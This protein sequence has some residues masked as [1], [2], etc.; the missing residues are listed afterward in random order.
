MNDSGLARSEEDPASGTRAA[1]SDAAGAQMRSLLG[2]GA[3]QYRVFLSY[4]HADAKWAH[5]LMRRLEAYRV[6]ARFHG[7]VA[8]IGVVG[9]RI[10]PVFRDRDEL[11]T[12]S[13]LGETIR[14]ALRQS[15]TLVAICSPASLTS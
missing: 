12:T 2:G 15:A 14:T 8:P 1:G 13:D 9:P 10:A 4:S 5:W 3:R 6:P 11:P 7:L